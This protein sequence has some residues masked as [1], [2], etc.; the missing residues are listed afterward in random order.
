MHYKMTTPCEACPFLR[1]NGFTFRSLLRHASGQFPCH[2]ACD[3]DDDKGYVEKEGN[4]TPHCAGALI[5]LEKRNDQHMVMQ[6]ASRLGMYKPSELD[7]DA[8]VG[9]GP[10]DY[11]AETEYERKVEESWRSSCLA[12]QYSDSMVCRECGLRWDV[13]DPYPPPCR[14]SDDEAG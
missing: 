2:K 14:R 1:G 5:F 13:N 6:I 4:K 10:E 9:S 12:V 3:H 11:R 8:D 7:M